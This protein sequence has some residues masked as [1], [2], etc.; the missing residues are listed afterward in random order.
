MNDAE[1]QEIIRETDEEYERGESLDSIHTTEQYD[2]WLE[3]WI[4][5]SWLHYAASHGL[6]ADVESDGDQ[7]SATG[8][9]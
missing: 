5:K 4:R 9:S 2:K 7:K 8:P 3:I 1:F 6:S